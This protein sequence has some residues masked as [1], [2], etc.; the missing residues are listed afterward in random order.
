MTG[1]LAR[2]TTWPISQMNVASSRA[3]AIAPN[4]FKDVSPRAFAVGETHHEQAGSRHSDRLHI[5]RA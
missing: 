2:G 3:T 4:R 5:W 1:Q